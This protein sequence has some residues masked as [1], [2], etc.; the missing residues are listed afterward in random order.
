MLRAVDVP[1]P[2]E[3]Q[4]F[5]RSRITNERARVT[6]TTKDTAATA[7][8]TTSNPQQEWQQKKKDENCAL[9]KQKANIERFTA[10]GRMHHV[11]IL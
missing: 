3:N 1:L 8:A 11:S 4:L 10:V 6:L 7:A 5:V 9:P 2:F